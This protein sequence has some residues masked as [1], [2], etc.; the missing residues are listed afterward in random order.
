MMIYAVLLLVFVAGHA[1]SGIYTW[2]NENGVLVFSDNPNLAPKGIK[3][4]IW[5][6]TSSRQNETSIRQPGE[7]GKQASEIISKNKG[8]QP[9]R[10]Q[11]PMPAVSQ[12]AFAVQLTR[13]LGLGQNLSPED[14]AKILLDIRIAPP[15]GKW[16]LNSNI[17]PALTTRL[18]TL[19]VS[20]TQMGWMSI[21]P[22]QALLAFDTAAALMGLPIPLS[23]EPRNGKV[24]EPVLKVPPLVYISPPPP[25]IASSYTWV[26]VLSGFPFYGVR[27]HGYYVLHGTHLS[28]H[29]FNGHRFAFN[30]HL[31]QGHLLNHLPQHH[32]LGEY[33]LHHPNRRKAH[34][35][36]AISPPSHPIRHRQNIEHKRHLR[37]S[38]PK[39]SHKFQEEHRVRHHSPSPHLERHSVLRSPH[40]SSKSHTT[41]SAQHRSSG[42]SHRGQTGRSGHIR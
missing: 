26:P 12:G 34:R 17:T 40:V 5:R 36:T 25:L 11:T 27:V 39:N 9:R 14:A 41:S 33:R 21:T 42:G 30:A 18:R 4:K 37:Q 2:K 1:N 19:T 7:A 6:V 31:L 29:H 3:A 22:E 20:A 38:H 35:R 28:A 23:P 16:L 10:P 15:L 32:D 24:S 13:E 8:E